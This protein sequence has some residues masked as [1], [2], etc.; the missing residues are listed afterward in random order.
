MPDNYPGDAKHGDNQPHNRNQN[1]SRQ[2]Q[3]TTGMERELGLH[4]EIGGGTSPRG[5]VTEQ[6]ATFCIK[7]Y[8]LVPDTACTMTLFSG[9]KFNPVYAKLTRVPDTVNRLR[10]T[11]FRSC[12]LSEGNG[13]GKPITSR[14]CVGR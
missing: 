13:L 10:P 11:L 14:E 2:A 9:K 1:A 4:K 7:E 8:R 12:L 6:R 5:K 3:D